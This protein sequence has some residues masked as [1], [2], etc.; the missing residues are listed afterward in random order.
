MASVT[1][2]TPDLLLTASLRVSTFRASLT[3]ETTSSV[4]QYEL[5]KL[6]AWTREALDAFHR[7]LGFSQERLDCIHELADRYPRACL[8]RTYEPAE[9]DT[10]SS[11]DGAP[12]SPP[13][14]PRGRGPGLS[15]KAWTRRINA[16]RA[17][18][19]RVWDTG[20]DDYAKWR[21]QMKSEHAHKALSTSSLLR[22]PGVRKKQRRPAI[23][24]SER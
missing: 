17:R 8:E 7:L 13:P 16:D 2:A 5:S 10:D 1:E 18:G 4:S 15:V 12:L 20:F 6:T 24:V 11:D 14:S 22:K 21:S 9:S 3:P 23:A 19:I